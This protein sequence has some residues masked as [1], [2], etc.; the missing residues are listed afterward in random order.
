MV[1]SLAYGADAFREGAVESLPQFY[2]FYENMPEFSFLLPR[3]PVS[4]A[5]MDSGSGRQYASF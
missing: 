4:Y 3:P 5:Y 2:I 1:A